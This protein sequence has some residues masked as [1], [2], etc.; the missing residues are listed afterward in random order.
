MLVDD[1]PSSGATRTGTA[2]GNGING[3]GAF[4]RPRAGRT[5]TVE[6]PHAPRVQR[7]RQVAG[8]VT[9]QPDAHRHILGRAGEI[10]VVVDLNLVGL[11][12]GH[13][14]PTQCGVL[15]LVSAPLAGASSTVWPGLGGVMMTVQVGIH[16]P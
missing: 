8:D 6:R 16:A 15:S 11:P 14:V 2:G 7:I 1:A 10:A 3:E 13:G 4:V 12:V 5:D 9:R